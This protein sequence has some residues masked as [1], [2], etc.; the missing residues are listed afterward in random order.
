[1]SK[2][3]KAGKFSSKGRTLKAKKR[4]TRSSISTVDP[5]ILN[6]ESR[7]T[8]PESIRK[9]HPKPAVGAVVFHREKVLLVKRTNPPQ[10]DLW[11]IPGGSVRLGETLQQAA[12]REIRE[13]TGL[14]VKAGEPIHTF[15][16]IDRSPDGTILFHYV[17]VDLRADYISGKIK[18]SDD[19]ADAA[20]FSPEDI[21]KLKISSTTQT[22]LL[23][24]GFIH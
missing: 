17:I 2:N 1:M 16:I 7:Q 19:A 12:E 3:N 23:K 14:T 4:N 24:L 21:K 20:W 15:D 13:E 6:Q 8:V 9:H 5:V 22:L 10:K 18:A 11:A